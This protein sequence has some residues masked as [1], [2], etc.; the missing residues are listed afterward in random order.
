MEEHGAIERVAGTCLLVTDL[1]AHRTDWNRA[2]RIISNVLVLM[3]GRC[4]VGD[5]A[6]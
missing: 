2:V 3:Y 5:D 6:Q 1:E 4:G